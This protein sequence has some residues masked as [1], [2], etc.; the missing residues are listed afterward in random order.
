MVTVQRTPSAVPA[1]NSGSGRSQSGALVL[2]TL[3]DRS[4]FPVLLNRITKST[5]APCRASV[6]AAVIDMVISGCRTL[7]ASGSAVTVIGRPAASTAVAVMVLVNDRSGFTE[8][9]RGTDSPGASVGIS[10]SAQDGGR[11]GV[12]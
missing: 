1:G 5:L 11:F 10:S 7:I 4:T 8:Q 9:V 6:G 3:T 12:E 2:V